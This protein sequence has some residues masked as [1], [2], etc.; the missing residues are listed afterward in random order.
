MLACMLWMAPDFGCRVQ[1]AS[2]R[3]RAGL[4]TGGGGAACPDDG[5]CMRCWALPG[6][7]R[8]EDL[9]RGAD[10]CGCDSGTR[11][12]T[13][14]ARRIA[15]AIVGDAPRSAPAA[16]VAVRTAEVQFCTCRYTAPHTPSSRM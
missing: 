14:R 13:Q 11:C 3:L 6:R 12:G 5:E 15:P 16:G 10:T 1:A 9:A 2:R 4:V 7:W 8:I